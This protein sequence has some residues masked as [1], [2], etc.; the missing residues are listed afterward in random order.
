MSAVREAPS[1]KAR[2]GAHP[3][4]FRY[5]FKDKPGLY[6]RVKVA[7]PP[8]QLIGASGTSGNAHNMTEDQQHVHVQVL[9]KNGKEMDPVDYFNDSNTNSQ[10]NFADDK[11]PYPAS[12]CSGGRCE[13]APPPEKKDK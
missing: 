2:E 8:G 5:T 6:F 4:L 7:H 9:D 3:Q 10:K 12:S 13:H 11:S 1:R